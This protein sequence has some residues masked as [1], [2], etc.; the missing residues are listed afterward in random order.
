MGQFD[1][2]SQCGQCVEVC[3]GAGCVKVKV[4]DS[5]ASC[6]HGDIDLSTDALDACTG[7]NWDRKPVS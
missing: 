7:Y 2:D 5:C 1:R 3:G 4:V 6:S